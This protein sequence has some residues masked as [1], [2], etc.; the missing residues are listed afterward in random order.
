[1]KYSAPILSFL[2][3][4]G[5]NQAVLTPAACF[6]AGDQA[7]LTKAEEVHSL[8]LDS[9]AQ[10]HPVRLRGIVTY[11]DADWLVFYI[12][13]PSGG[14]QAE[15]RQQN[16]SLKPGQLVEVSGFKVHDRKYRLKFIYG[17]RMGKQIR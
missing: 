12:Q 13:D 7:V 5:L 10:T 2:L 6:A 16:Y 17:Q 8:S 11:V 14:I 1:M 15:L 3:I 9:A 4:S